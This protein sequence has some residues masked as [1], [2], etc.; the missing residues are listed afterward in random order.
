MTFKYANTSFHGDC[1]NFLSYHSCQIEGE[2]ALVTF[3]VPTEMMDPFKNLLVSAGSLAQ[4][5][6]VKTKVALALKKAQCPVLLAE[7]RKKYKKVADRIL[8]RFDHY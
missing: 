5:T 3:S 8:S 6:S 7:S 2:N 1:V 4:F